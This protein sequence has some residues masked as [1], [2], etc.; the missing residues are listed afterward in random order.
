VPD[1]EREKF[2]L[3][4]LRLLVHAGA[5]CPIP[6]KRRII[7]ALPCEISELYGAS[8]GG[9]T[10]INSAEWLERPGSVGT[11]WPGV[12]VRILDEDGR[13]VPT[14]ETGVVYIAPPGTS[15]FH[16][17]DD[18]DKTT[19]AWRDN[20]FTVGDVGHLDEA[21]YLFLT[22]RNKDKIVRGG[23]NV[24][25]VEVEEALAR[26]SADDFL[27]DG[28]GVAFDGD[29]TSFARLQPRIHV[30][31]RDRARRTGLLLRLRRAARRGRGPDFAAAARGRRVT[32]P[33]REA[34]DGR[35]ALGASEAG[36]RDRRHGVDGRRP[37]AA[38]ALPRPAPRQ[39]RRRRGPGARRHEGG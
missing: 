17:H 5:P 32:V 20:A 30:S 6:V 10:R 13:P 37:A 11:P 16:Y 36:G 2:D 3:S 14:G 4:S 22:D 18:E 25:P 28:E 33:A 12:E 29:R 27:L 26:Q 7:E 8:E 23:E 9:A 39:E 21:G 35:R 31:D 19:Q 34:A 15:R 1:E 24:Y 38:P